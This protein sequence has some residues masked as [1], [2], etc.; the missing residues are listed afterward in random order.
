M[1][2]VSKFCCQCSYLR[3]NNNFSFLTY[4][5]DI[6]IYRRYEHLY[7]SWLTLNVLFLKR[8]LLENIYFFNLATI[9]Y[10]FL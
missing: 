1:Y 7:Y 9:I 3:L 2:R 10:I 5:L 4:E 8:D 6:Y